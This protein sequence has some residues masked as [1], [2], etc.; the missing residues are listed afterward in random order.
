VGDKKD[1]HYRK[2]AQEHLKEQGWV[3]PTFVPVKALKTK[4]APYRVVNAKDL[5]SDGSVVI[6]K[7]VYFRVLGQEPTPNAQAVRDFC[8][9]KNQ[10]V[11]EAL[12]KRLQELERKR[13]QERVQNA[14]YAG[15]ILKEMAIRDRMMDEVVTGERH[16]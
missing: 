12:E 6:E 10:E 3:Q 7:T 5:G 9:Q 11:K 8:A 4:G 14:R 13:V 2:S 16:L 15:I 1:K